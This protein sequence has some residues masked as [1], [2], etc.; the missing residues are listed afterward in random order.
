MVKKSDAFWTI[1]FRI[2]GG[3]KGATMELAG[4]DRRSRLPLVGTVFVDFV[5]GGA[6]FV[7]RQIASPKL[8]G[9]YG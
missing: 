1:G 9:K 7:G 3:R 8:C 4:H 5:G 6:E 2:S